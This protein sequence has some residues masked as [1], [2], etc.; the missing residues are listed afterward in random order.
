MDVREE[1]ILKIAKI[2]ERVKFRNTGQARQIIGRKNP[3]KSVN[4]EYLKKF[5]DSCMWND[6]IPNFFFESMYENNKK[7]I[8]T[9]PECKLLNNKPNIHY[10]SVWVKN[11]CADLNDI[12]GSIIKT[13]E[14]IELFLH[15]LNIDA[16]DP[17]ADPDPS[18][19]LHINIFKR[20]FPDW[21]L[22]LKVGLI[23]PFFLYTD[24]SLS[25]YYEFI[26]GGSEGRI[27]KYNYYYKKYN[28]DGTLDKVL[29]KTFGKYIK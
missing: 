23:S 15:D 19:F 8:N 28:K 26:V 17:S 2:Y 25:K 9:K 24:E 12:S 7:F 6:Y 14:N 11:N 1:D 4:Y 5:T 29:N 21:I 16:E 10:Y 20:M 22:M 27:G 13:K 18:R 3:E